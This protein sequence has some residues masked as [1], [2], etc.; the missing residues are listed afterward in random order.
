[1]LKALKNRHCHTHIVIE[2]EVPYSFICTWKL[3][4]GPAVIYFNSFFGYYEYPSEQAFPSFIHFN[5]MEA[6]M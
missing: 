5:N 1:M 4:D 3:R 6:A 2:T